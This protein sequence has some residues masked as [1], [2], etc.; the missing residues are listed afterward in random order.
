MQKIY[1]D[2]ALLNIKAALTQTQ[3]EWTDV[4]LGQ[5][6]KAAFR[7]GTP[8][9]MMLMS[10]LRLSLEDTYARVAKSASVN[11]LEFIDYFDVL[12]AGTPSAAF[13]IPYETLPNIPLGSKDE[14][15]PHVWP[16]DR[17]NPN[18]A[19]SVLGM[20]LLFVRAYKNKYKAPR[21]MQS[22][23]KPK[24]KLPSQLPSYAYPEHAALGTAGERTQFLD[25][26]FARILGEANRLR[27]L[28]VGLQDANKSEED[29]AQ[30]VFRPVV[31]LVVNETT[32]IIDHLRSIQVGTQTHVAAPE[33]VRFVEDICH[34][35]GLPHLSSTNFSNLAMNSSET[36]RLAFD[37]AD[38]VMGM[39]LAPR[40]G[41]SVDWL[42]TSSVDV[43]VSMATHFKSMP[44]AISLDRHLAPGRAFMQRMFASGWDWVPKGPSLSALA[45]SMKPPQR[46]NADGNEEEEE[47]ESFP[48]SSYAL[49]DIEK[50][51]ARVMQFVRTVN[52]N[53]GIG[54][55]ETRLLKSIIWKLER[56]QSKRPLEE[57]L[58]IAMT[59]LERCFKMWSATPEKKRRDAMWYL[60]AYCNRM[61][62][63]GKLAMNLNVRQK[64]FVALDAARI[65]LNR[66]M[67]ADE[68][69]KLAGM[70][71][72]AQNVTAQSYKKLMSSP[73]VTLGL[74]QQDPPISDLTLE[75]Y[76]NPA[77]ADALVDADE[78]RD[79]CV[80][81]NPRFLLRG[82]KPDVCRTVDRLAEKARAE[83]DRLIELK[84][85]APFA[86]QV[87]DQIWKLSQS[88]F[89]TATSLSNL[90]FNDLYVRLGD[91]SLAVHD[92][93][94]VGTVAEGELGKLLTAAGV[95]SPVGFA[96]VVCM[97]GTGPC[98]K[99]AEWLNY[100]AID[101]SAT[102]SS[103]TFGSSEQERT[104]LDIMLKFTQQAEAQDLELDLDDEDLYTGSIRRPA[105]FRTSR[106]TKLMDVIRLPFSMTTS[107]YIKTAIASIP[108][109][110]AGAIAAN[111]MW[112]PIDSIP[113]SGSYF[114]P[115]APEQAA[116]DLTKLVF[117]GVGPLIRTAGNVVYTGYTQLANS[118]PGI[119]S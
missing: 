60:S 96:T 100:L 80:P 111:H 25:Q 2:I 30:N 81:L 52:K 117:G 37:Q 103:V 41:V 12:Y 38:S 44:D 88:T 70:F 110:M 82:L 112:T 98:Q 62:D 1:R 39:V 57:R 43:A 8:I 114:V 71:T 113:V 93:V 65:L 63:K 35:L 73:N 49:S 94:L 95:V 18:E 13:E 75:I 34:Y 74:G 55:E 86:T 116:G 47:D 53:E 32:T 4:T 87:T 61:E 58:G 69:Q 83:A 77:N 22:S 10:R 102:P 5:I 14:K 118:L 105:N 51:Q 42:K 68:F 11:L 40:T 84:K 17:R 9:P 27:E 36:R 15:A 115:G 6:M 67:D 97:A 33:V 89:A 78:D 108:L 19:L 59:H 90:V 66:Q 101:K 24:E 23:A 85:N 119:G 64:F 21:A 16:E 50:I 107:G 109:S 92:Q 72:I 76:A 104:L 91:F 46:K 45:E 106:P 99:L 20:A 48:P 28:Y 29:Y 26:E 31:I 79:W 7:A 3:A 54:A 56:Q